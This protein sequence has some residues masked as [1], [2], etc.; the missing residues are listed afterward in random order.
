M[1]ALLA[2]A[3]R[4]AV[5]GSVA[6]LV[7]AARVRATGSYST[8]T[9]DERIER[10]RTEADIRLRLARPRGAALAADWASLRLDAIERSGSS[11]VQQGTADADEVRERLLAWIARPGRAKRLFAADVERLGDATPEAPAARRAPGCG[12]RRAR[13]LRRS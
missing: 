1:R 10:L 3:D 7:E 6:A 11:P 13:P 2:R 9:E 8:P 4:D 5:A 12:R